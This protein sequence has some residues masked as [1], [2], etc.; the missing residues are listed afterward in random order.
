MA[1]RISAPANAGSGGPDGPAGPGE[2]R[3][4]AAA[5]VDLWERHLTF[6]AAQG[7]PLPQRRE[8]RAPAPG[9][10]TRDASDA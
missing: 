6:L 10:A 4:R 2:D 7:V 5:Y 1:Q 8:G 3:R 9:R